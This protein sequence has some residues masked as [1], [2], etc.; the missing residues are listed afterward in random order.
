MDRII[1]GHPRPYDMGRFNGRNFTYIASLG[2]F[3]KVSYSTPQKLKN[4]IGHTAYIFEG[5]K[6]IGNITPFKAEVSANGKTVSGEFIFGSVSNSTSIAGLFKLNSLDVRLDDGELELMLIRNPENA[7]ALTRIINGLTSGVYD[8]DHVIFTHIREMT[9]H[10]EKP[11][12][13]TLDGESGGEQ[14]DVH[15]TVLH[16]SIRLIV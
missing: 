11:I 12:G 1:G 13:W 14:T 3:T 4:A 8:P 9:M 6:E 7:A 10:T 15:I 2:A 5:V 16:N